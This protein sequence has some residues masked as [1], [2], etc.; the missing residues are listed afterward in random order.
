MMQKFNH[1]Q[2]TVVECQEFWPQH[3]KNLSKQ[4]RCDSVELIVGLEMSPHYNT[5][6]MLCQLWDKMDTNSC[7]FYGSLAKH[8]RATITF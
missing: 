8:I 6:T 4:I 3:Q 2:I 7:N 1:Y 5:M